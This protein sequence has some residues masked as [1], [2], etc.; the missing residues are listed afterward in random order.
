M[1]PLN[2]QSTELKT[3]VFF[4]GVAAGNGGQFPF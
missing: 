4:G 1:V 2:H 3:L